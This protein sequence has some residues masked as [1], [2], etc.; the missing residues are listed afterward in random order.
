MVGLAPTTTDA[1][2]WNVLTKG[3]DGYRQNIKSGNENPSS[4]PALVAVVRAV[5]F[6]LAFDHY[7]GGGD[8]LLVVFA[9]ESA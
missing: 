4:T 2:R 7:D 8:W 9:A 1:G 5:Q 6:A 3:N